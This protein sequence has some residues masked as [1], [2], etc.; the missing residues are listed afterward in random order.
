MYLHGMMVK[1]STVSTFSSQFEFIY[2]LVLREKDC[3]FM[4]GG[5]INV[6]Q[7][8]AYFHWKL[9]LTTSG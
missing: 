1:L 6:F 9:F 8:F 4:L 2:G 5:H 7:N 3:T